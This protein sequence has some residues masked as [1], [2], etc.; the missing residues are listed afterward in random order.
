MSSVRPCFNHFKT[1]CNRL[2]CDYSHDV[3]IYKSFHG[4]K[5]CP[6]CDKFCKTSSKQCG[7]CVEKWV[8]QKG[9]EKLRFQEFQAKRNVC[10]FAE[11]CTNPNCSRTHPESRE[12]CKIDKSCTDPDCNKLHFTYLC[13]RDDDCSQFGCRYRH[14]DFSSDEDKIRCPHN[15]G[16]RRCVFTNVENGAR[17]KYHKSENS[18]DIPRCIVCDKSSIHHWIKQKLSETDGGHDMCRGCFIL[19]YDIETWRKF[20]ESFIV[21]MNANKDECENARKIKIQKKK[22]EDEKTQKEFE[23]YWKRC[24]EENERRRKQYEN[25]YREKAHFPK[26]SVSNSDYV[27]GFEMLDSRQQQVIRSMMGL[28]GFVTLTEITIDKVKK[29][30]R[31]LSMKYHPDKP[32]GNTET[33]QNISNARDYMNIMLESSY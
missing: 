26:P 16:Y 23:E 24:D 6:S 5:N 15:E 1:Q 2:K 21:L 33:Y 32:G 8:K 14:L 7:K 25:A 30:F 20:Y 13:S 10:K 18:R 17:C 27:P 29:T 22:E 19:H 12:L 4:L 3:E 28:Y 11:L 31:V 9:V